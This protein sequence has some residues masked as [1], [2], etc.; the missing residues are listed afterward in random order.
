MEGSSVVCALIG[1]ETA[2]RRWVR[3]EIQR[4]VWDG[5][6]ILAV[7]VHTISHFTKATTTPGLYPLDLLGVYV[8]VTTAGKSVRLIER[9]STS[10]DWTYSLTSPR[11][12]RNGH[13]ELFRVP[14]ATR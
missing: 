5:R 12:S 10:A 14:A 6:G 8:E 7:R 11:F 1:K 4:G 3:H 2:S 9:T 13:T